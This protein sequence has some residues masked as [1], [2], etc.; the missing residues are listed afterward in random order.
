MENIS[1][2]MT[3][4]LVVVAPGFNLAATMGF[5]DPFRAANYLDGTLYFK[6]DFV[7]E[8]GGY[9][10]AS[11]G[12]GI[13]T[14]ALG[15]VDAAD[16]VVVSTSWTPEKHVTQKTGNA[17]RHWARSGATLGG[18]DTG[19]FILAWA[20]LLKGRRATVHY[21]HIDAFQELY[22]DVNV[23]ENLFVL[24]GNRI[25]CCGGNASVDFGLQIVKGVCG[26]ALANAAA[27]YIFHDRLRGPS[28]LQQPQHSEPL[29]ST[30]PAKLR[31]AIQEMEANLENPIPVPEIC[32]KAGIS[33]RQLD[34]LFGTYIKKTPALYYRDIRL[35]RAR[36]LVTQTEL[37]IAEVAVASGFASQVHFSRAYK[38]RF[39]L[40]PTRDRVDGRVPFEFRAWP[41]HRKSKG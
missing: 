5:I 38:E 22:P 35:D 18:L 19:A 36:G 20:G 8:D 32:K 2:P 7:S 9:C 29:G 25:S 31:A 30:V 28:D 14:V 27:R 4:V 34:R 40:P 13:N 6:W 39:G 16:I 37:P 10:I 15:D 23:V 11:N 12:A 26:S 17:L 41:M 24:D 33:H 1:D 3:R 21:E